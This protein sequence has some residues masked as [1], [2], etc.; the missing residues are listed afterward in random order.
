MSYARE[1]SAALR[2]AARC[3]DR[4]HRFSHCL[5]IVEMLRFKDPRS[6]RMAECRGLAPL[7]RRHAHVSTEARFARPVDIPEPC[8]S[9]LR[10]PNKRRSQT[11]ATVNWSAWRGLHLHFRRFEL[12]ASALGY[13]RGAHGRICTDTVRVL[14]ALSLHWTTWAKLV[15][16]E[17][18]PPPTSPS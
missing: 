10:P 9:G 12:C 4:A 16:R 1:W 8:S 15:P 11:V 7:A 17:G 14:S 6:D 13:T 18:F 2:A 3:R 5:D